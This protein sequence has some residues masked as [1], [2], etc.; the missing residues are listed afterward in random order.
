MAE[1]KSG[2]FAMLWGVTLPEFDRFAAAAGGRVSE[3]EATL[4]ARHLHA[5]RHWW[6]DHTV[7][8]AKLDE[9]R[10][11]RKSDVRSHCRDMHRE[12]RFHKSH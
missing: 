12:T 2:D 10:Q 3:R 8:V 6:R 4:A 7:G 9:A 11:A 1:N 5:G